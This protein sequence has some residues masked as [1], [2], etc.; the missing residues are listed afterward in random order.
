MLFADIC[1]FMALWPP[2][3]CLRQVTILFA[4]ICGFTSMSEKVD[5]DGVMHFLNTLYSR[6]DQLLDDWGVY[7]VETVGDC[8]GKPYEP[9][10]P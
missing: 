1:A 4:D 10:A 9:G 5:P 7:K 3:Y 8:Y 2:F 6:Y